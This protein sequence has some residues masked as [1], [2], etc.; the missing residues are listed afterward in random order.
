MGRKMIIR[1]FSFLLLIAATEVNAAEWYRLTRAANEGAITYIDATSISI[2]QHGT[3]RAWLVAINKDK[4]AIKYFKTVKCKARE[5][6]TLSSVKYTTG[7]E[8]ENSFDNKSPEYS[9]IVP[10]TIGEIIL[11]VI[12]SPSIKQYAIKRGGYYTASPAV[13]AEIEFNPPA[14]PADEAPSAEAYSPAD[15]APSAEAY[16]PA[17]EVASP[18]GDIL[19][20]PSNC[21]G[22]CATGYAWAIQSKPVQ[23]KSCYSLPD[24]RDAVGCIMWMERNRPYSQ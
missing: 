1:A 24:T 19:G 20:Q 17:D 5:V 8:V 12:C 13:S 10:E 14:P 16:S 22:R 15:E 7:G 21:L 9:P 23:K 3:R 2:T 18:Y 11:E 4:S 6:A